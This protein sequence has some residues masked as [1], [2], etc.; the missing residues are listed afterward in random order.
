MHDEITVE[1][2]LPPS[3][4]RVLPGHTFQTKSFEGLLQK[5]TLTADGRLVLHRE[6]WEEVPEEER[7]FYGTPRWDTPLGKWFGSMRAVPVGDEEVPHHGDAR[8]YDSFRVE[9]EEGARVWIEYEARFTEGILSRSRVAEVGELPPP[10]GTWELGD[11]QLPVH[12]SGF[13][14]DVVYVGEEVEVERDADGRVYVYPDPPCPRRSVHPCRS[15][16][17]ASSSSVLS[18]R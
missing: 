18:P 1:Y 15:Q 6:R 9:G 7:R 12:D 10:K 14:F 11:R 16:I 3:G 17:A 5:Y 8:F 13:G 2:P 4:Y